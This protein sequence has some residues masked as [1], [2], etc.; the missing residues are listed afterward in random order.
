MAC[1]FWFNKSLTNGQWTQTSGINRGVNITIEFI[2]I[3]LAK[4]VGTLEPEVTWVV[5]QIGK[6]RVWL[7]SFKREFH[8]VTDGG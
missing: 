5:H 6:E 7:I 4:T 3:R 1:F 8:R 2:R